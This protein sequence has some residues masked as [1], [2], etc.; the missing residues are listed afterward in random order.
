MHSVNELNV[1]KSQSVECQREVVD[2]LA[3]RFFRLAN[4]LPAEALKDELA[5][6][7]SENVRQALRYCLLAII[8]ADIAT[9][10]Y[11]EG[12]EFHMQ[13]LAE[14]AAA[15]GLSVAKIVHMTEYADEMIRHFQVLEKKRRP[16]QPTRTAVRRASRRP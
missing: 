3:A 6:L 10:P 11:P 14:V 5:A 2:E 12:R 9:V 13:T 15:Y 8:A 1:I 4:P 7:A 16:S